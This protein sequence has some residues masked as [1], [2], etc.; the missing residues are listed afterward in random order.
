M[1]ASSPR[2]PSCAMRSVKCTFAHT[3]RTHIDF[4]MTDQE[5]K[6]IVASLAVGQAKTDAQLAKTDAQLAK[7]DAKLDRL[8]S[9]YG[10]VADNQG[11]AAEEFF[12][13][14]LSQ[15][16]QI[17]PIHFDEVLSKVYG[18]KIGAQQEYDLVLLN[19]DCAAIVE[20]KYKVHPAAL[21][22]LHKQLSLFKVHFPEHQHMKLY[23]GVAGFSVPD[24]VTEQAHASGYFVLKRQG[25][26]F[27]VDAQ[28][29]KAF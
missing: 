16:K 1:T 7:T 20:V 13:N 12:F 21:E 10:G 15:A 6:D 11:S 4:A 14:S 9:L 22:Q 3:R 18:G 2:H 19:G 28:R 24:E 29:M 5:L 23:G 8:A 17:G 26:S 27:A 25:E